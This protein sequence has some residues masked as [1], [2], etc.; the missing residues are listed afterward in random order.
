MSSP[1]SSSAIGDDGRILQHEAPSAVPDMQQQLIPGLSDDLALQCL[2]RLPRSKLHSLRLVCKSWRQALSDEYLPRLRAE[3]GV[4]ERWLCVETWNA[5]TMSVSW[6]S[7]DHVYGRW[8]ELPPVPP[9]SRG[10][11]SK[12][13][14]GRASGVVAGHLVVAGGLV[15]AKH[16]SYT[17]RDVFAYS[18]LS[19]TWQRRKDMMQARHS[20]IF[21][22]LQGRL[23]VLGGF[24]AANRPLPSHLKSECYDFE[25]DEWH[26]VRNQG[27]PI[28][29]LPR[30]TN[31]R[32]RT[33]N[34]VNHSLCCQYPQGS[35]F[36]TSYDP[37]TGQWELGGPPR[38]KLASC[39]SLCLWY[40]L[41]DR[42]QRR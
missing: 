39:V 19:N 20:P 21:G 31:R 15:A 37:S 32:W 27:H 38:S 16:G 23:Y 25:R 30:T 2:A 22:V 5:R 3:L 29:S 18:P 42:S 33:F 4:T 35:R 24:D 34:I 7:F 41:K 36:L 12:Q 13:I 40:L 10:C 1:C 17:L 11:D 28:N 9:A 8:R 26:E 14:M 6:K